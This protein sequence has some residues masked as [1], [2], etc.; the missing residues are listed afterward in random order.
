M[1]HVVDT[2]ARR[3]TLNHFG[4]RDDA[5]FEAPH[6]VRG[7]TRERHFHDDARALEGAGPVDI[8][9]VAADQPALFEP[10]HALPCR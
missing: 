3:M 8:R 9:A 4:R 5:L 1:Q 7:M 6:V 10:S 2:A